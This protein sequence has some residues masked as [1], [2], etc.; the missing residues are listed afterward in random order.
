MIYNDEKYFVVL[1]LIL[2]ILYKSNMKK[3][4]QFLI[5]KMFKIYEK[6]LIKIKKIEKYFE[7]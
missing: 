7:F 6:M 2:K 3:C 4:Y 5:L 1:V